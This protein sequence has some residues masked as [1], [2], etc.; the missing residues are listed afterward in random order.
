MSERVT[1][2]VITESEEETIRLGEKVSLVAVPPLLIALSGELGAGKTTFV[3]GLARGLGVERVRSPSF[4]IIQ[5]YRCK[6]TLY[7]VDLYRISSV[8]EL[9]PLGLLDIFFDPE[10]IVVIEWAEKAFRYLPFDYL[11]L[12]MKILGP[13]KR[14]IEFYASSEKTRKLLKKLKDLL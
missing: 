3:K 2:R 13:T 9:I 12:K 6:V 14:E 4:I 1:H 8:E 11:L 10:A 5:R 7:H